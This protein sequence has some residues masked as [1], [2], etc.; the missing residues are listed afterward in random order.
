MGDDGT[1]EVS[2]EITVALVPAAAAALIAEEMSSDLDQVDVVNRALQIY[3]HLMEEIRQH[4][5]LLI[6]D[7]ETRRTKPVYFD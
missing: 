5:Q 6:R 2:D 3:H 4:N 1:M 7:V